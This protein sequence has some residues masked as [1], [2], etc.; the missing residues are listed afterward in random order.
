MSVKSERIYRVTNRILGDMDSYTG[1]MTKDLKRLYQNYLKPFRIR[2]I[3]A[4]LV[5]CIWSL[6]PYGAALLT[7]YL[8]DKVLMVDKNS[9]FSQQLPLFRNY[10]F[11]LF[12]L[13]TIFV[14]CNWLKNWLILGVGQKMIF[15]LRKQLHE[16]LQNLHIGYFERNESG[17]VVS[18]V[19]DDVKLIREWS[20]NQFLNFTA[21]IF[22]LLFGLIIIVFINW[23][24]SILIILS[25]PIYAWS[26]IKIRPV[27]RRLNIAIRKLNAEMYALS[28]ER[29]S[30]IDVVKAFSQEQ[31]ERNTFAQKMNNYI[32]LAMRVIFHQQKL[33]LFAGFITS[34]ISGLIIYLSVLAVKNGTMS[35]GDLMAFIQIMPNLFSQ[36]N[37]LITIMTSIEAVFVVIHRVFG[38]LDEP[39]SVAP[40]LINLDG[41]TGKIRFDN[42][43]FKYPGQDD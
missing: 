43:S 42:I 16:K 12:S 30:G 19:L 24:L 39:E 34:V 1:S 5:T 41:M 35:F 17:K 29:I 21:S 20:T 36:V 32:R 13:W 6:F 31:R 37:A 7:R 8:V 3:L 22:R 38:L 25:L 27:I 18:R 33:S 9:G 11:M 40:G 10:V 28:A 15:T 26:F 14:I 23:K 2:I 4:L